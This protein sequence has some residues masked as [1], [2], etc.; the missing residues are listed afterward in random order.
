MGMRAVVLSIPQGTLVISSGDNT[1]LAG[2]RP[3][4]LAVGAH[5]ELAV[6]VS[7]S[8]INAGNVTFYFDRKGADG[9]WYP[10]WSSGA[11]SVPGLASTSLGF[12]QANQGSFGLTGRLR[13][14]L[15]GGASSV[16]F[17]AS[18]VGK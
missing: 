4:G 5:D 11:L 6:D 17:S 12:G 15:A 8:A 10:V 13:W 14:V 16:T 9:V 18:I 1:L 2:Q 3:E 7:V